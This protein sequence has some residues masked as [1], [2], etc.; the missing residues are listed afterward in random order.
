MTD[1]LLARIEAKI[2]GQ[3]LGGFSAWKLPSGAWQVNLKLPSGGFDCK[4][5]PLTLEDALVEAFG[6][7]QPTPPAEDWSDV[8]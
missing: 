5:F 1:T 6:L 8:I 7:G 3:D 2:D 4:T